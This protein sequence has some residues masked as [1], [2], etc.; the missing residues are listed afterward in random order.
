MDLGQG[1]D[2]DGKCLINVQECGR[3]VAAMDFSPGGH[4]VLT[5]GPD[6]GMKLNSRGRRRGWYTLVVQ[7]R[8]PPLCPAFRRSSQCSSGSALIKCWLYAGERGPGALS[9]SSYVL[10]WGCAHKL[11]TCTHSSRT[12]LGCPFRLPVYPPRVPLGPSNPGYPVTTASSKP[13]LEDSS[14]LLRKI[15]SV[16]NF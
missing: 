3:V 16:A 10:A 2:L 15:T 6:P 13:Y 7:G 4:V 8:Q 5:W 1:G 12:V 14:F 11:H 9:V